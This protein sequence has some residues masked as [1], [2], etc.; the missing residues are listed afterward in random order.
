MRPLAAIPHAVAL[1]ASLSA[2]P[3]CPVDE[4]G[5]AIG[6]PMRRGCPLELRQ[7]LWAVQQAARSD[8]CELPGLEAGPDGE[9]ELRTDPGGL[10]FDAMDGEDPFDC[11]SFDGEMSCQRGDPEPLPGTGVGNEVQVRRKISLDF[12]NRTEAKGE[13]TVSVSCKRSGCDA[14]YYAELAGVPQLPCAVTLGVTAEFIGD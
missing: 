1:A 2:L 10:V 8:T 4:C 6:F 9:F 5:Q 12:D 11:G 14:E 3:G 13:R 7:G